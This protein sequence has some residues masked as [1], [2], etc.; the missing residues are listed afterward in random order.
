MGYVKTVTR[1][2]S[3]YFTTGLI[4]TYFPVYLTIYFK[5]RLLNA[6]NS[7][8][9]TQSF[10]VANILIHGRGKNKKT[11]SNVDVN[12]QV[13]TNQTV[14]YIRISLYS[15]LL[16]HNKQFSCDLAAPTGTADIHYVYMHTNFPVLAVIPKR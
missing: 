4:T 8:K 15:W 10:P 14:V 7:E 11:L 6:L 2:W 1:F 9:K 13:T 16:L 5:R 3:T 12:S